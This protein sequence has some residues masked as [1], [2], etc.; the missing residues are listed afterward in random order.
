MCVQGDFYFYSGIIRPVIVTE[1]PTTDTKWIDRVDVVSKDYVKG[2]IELRVAFGGSTTDTSAHLSISINGGSFGAFTAYPIVN[3]TCIIPNV[4][5]PNFK[6][7][8]LG[9]DNTQNLF[10]VAVQD[11]QS[12]DTLMV[13]SG[14]RVLGIDQPTARITI[15]GEIVKLLGFN[16][17]TMWPDT[18]AAVTQEQEAA[19][20]ALVKSLNANYIRGAHYPQSQ[21]W[22]DMLDVAGVAIWEETLGP[23][24]STKDMSDPWFM[25]NHLTAVTSMVL[26]SFNHPAVIFH[27]F[28]N[29]GPSNDPAACIGYAAS[30]RTIKELVSQPAMRMVTWANNK[31]TSDACI[32]YEDVISFN[33]YPGW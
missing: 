27:A 17:H 22:L 30:A 16:R 14:L 21:S 20:L 31:L 29:E 26:T 28:F 13:R 4:A 18:G 2:L 19:D 11:S 9:Q 8:T 1:L 10:T 5:V 12:K 23:G 24:T 6:L 32:A 3:S 15:N 33:S 25:S 7:W